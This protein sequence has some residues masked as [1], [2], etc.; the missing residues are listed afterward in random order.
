MPTAGIGNVVFM[1]SLVVCGHKTEGGGGDNLKKLYSLRAKII[2]MAK[3]I[4]I[5]K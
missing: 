5:N 3:I 4:R 2:S 1:Y